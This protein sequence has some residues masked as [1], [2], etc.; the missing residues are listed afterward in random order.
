M[1]SNCKYLLNNDKY[2]LTIGNIW[3]KVDLSS[4]E[5]V[6]IMLK[7]PK[8]ISIHISITICVLFF[9][10]CV[11]GLFVLPTLVELLIDLPDNIGNRGEITP[12]GR[13]FV[14]TMAYAVLAPVLLAD[15]LMFA[16]LLRVRQ[17]KVFTEI[18]VALIR[19]VSWCCF[20]LCAA[21][22]GLG[23]YFQ[24]A[25]VVAFAAVFLG[26]CLRVVKNVIE[27]ATRIKS[28]HDLTV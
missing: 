27:E 11:A 7:I 28:E 19:G 14:H 17:G 4:C 3:F 8:K 23:I 18:S 1:L 5:G 25:F 2:I 22:C 21:F 9:L 15:G 10:I 24:L 13:A 12:F 20:L 16:L 26:T 6:L